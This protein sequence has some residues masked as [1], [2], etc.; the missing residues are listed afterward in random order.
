MKL[1]LVQRSVP[2]LL[3][4]RPRSLMRSVRAPFF[5]PRGHVVLSFKRTAVPVRIPAMRP[6]CIACCAARMPAA[7]LRHWCIENIGEKRRHSYFCHVQFELSGIIGRHRTLVPAEAAPTLQRQSESAL[8]LTDNALYYLLLVLLALVCAMHRS[9]AYCEET[10]DKRN[11][12]RLR[13]ISLRD[14]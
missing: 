6:S 9:I 2:F 3:R 1:V 5:S 10:D 4:S 12:H 8:R 13:Y 11:M 14:G 7:Y